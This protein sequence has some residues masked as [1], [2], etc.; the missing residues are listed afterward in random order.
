MSADATAASPV[1]EASVGG[2]G[3]PIDELNALANEFYGTWAMKRRIAIA[4]ELELDR[5]DTAL[6]SSL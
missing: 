6:K 5:I 1:E 2:P 4:V 3:G